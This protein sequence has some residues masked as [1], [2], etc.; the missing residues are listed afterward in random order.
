MHI[1]SCIRKDSKYSSSVCLFCSR[2]AFLVLSHILLRHLFSN[3]IYDISSYENCSIFLIIL[4]PIC[5]LS[6]LFAYFIFFLIMPFAWF[7]VLPCTFKMSNVINLNKSTQC[8]NHWYSNTALCV[9]KQWDFLFCSLLCFS[10][11]E[12]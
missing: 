8:S 11:I 9:V 12:N 3:L 7:G 5:F 1:H 2:H 4:L 6:C 10:V